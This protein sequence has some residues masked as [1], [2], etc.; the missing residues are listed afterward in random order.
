MAGLE[1]M[2][3]IQKIK[4]IKANP[5]LALQSPYNMRNVQPTAY[6]PEQG[7]V[8][9]VPVEGAA[10]VPQSYAPQ[11]LSMN[12]LTSKYSPEQL[13]QMDFSQYDTGSLGTTPEN[14]SW[15]NAGNIETGVKGLSAAAGLAGAYLGNKNYKLAKDMFG[16][17]KA[18]T[19][20]AIQNQASEYNTGLQNAGEVGMGLAGNTMDANAR[21]ARQAQLN[22]QKISTAPIG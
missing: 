15:L 11:G 8:P 17:E 10:A 3:P 21:A 18:A 20:R 19:N 12:D 4:A 5:G 16:F 1:G 13:G 14:S 9:N 22:S 7:V 2:T 6:T